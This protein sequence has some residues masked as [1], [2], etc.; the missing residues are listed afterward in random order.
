[1]SLIFCCQIA[2][3]QQLGTGRALQCTL[4]DFSVLPFLSGAQI[5][6][7]TSSGVRTSGRLH[8]Q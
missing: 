2:C 1:M 4:T 8:R 7:S 3:T 5:A 6:I